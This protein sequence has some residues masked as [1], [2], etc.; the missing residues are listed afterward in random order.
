MSSASS[1]AS[2][3]SSRLIVGGL[4]W[5]HRWTGL[6]ACLFF[7]MWFA[8]GAVMLF[9]PFPSLPMVERFARGE[10][11]QPA[12]IAV[13]PSRALE[14]NPAADSMQLRARDG[15]PVYVLSSDGKPPVVVDANSGR[16]LGD[17]DVDAAGRIAQAFSG[18]KPQRIDVGVEYDQWVVHQGFD[19]GRPYHRVVLDDPAGTVLYVSA[20]TGEVVQKT[21]RRQRVL[22][23]VGAVPHWLYWTAI[24]QHWS[25]WDSLVWWISLGALGSAVIGFFL[26]IYRYVRSRVRGG[27]GW[28]VYVSWWRWHHVLG[29]VAGLF[30]LGWVLSG[31][32]SMDHGRLF[33]RGSAGAPAVAAMSGLPLAARA[34]G[35]SLEALATVGLASSIELRAVAGRAFLQVKRQAGRSDVFLEGRDRSDKL[36]GDWILEGLREAY[37]SAASIKERPS[38]ASGLYRKAEELP[39]GARAFEIKLADRHLVYV[40]ATTGEILVDMDPSRRS[41]AW[42]YYA[43]H[44]YRLPGLA[45]R[46]ALRIPL[47]LLLLTGG[48][49]LSL[50]GVVIAYRRIRATVV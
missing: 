18:M 30:L 36:P 14:A 50:T 27:S 11:L 24:R 26:G 31:W 25:F 6:L 39:D 13:T 37:H 47:M 35:V 48:F 33:S 34:E 40:D 3:T 16:V 44:T 23:S 32:L 38:N 41:Y 12:G 22:N 8:S 49:A 21:T 19:A 45:D 29:L 9:E 7:A 28:R 42:L 10:T 4:V 46:D 43:L 15:Q 2:S 20:R 1:G 17:L 5:L